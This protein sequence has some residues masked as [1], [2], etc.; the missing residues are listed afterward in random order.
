MLINHLVKLTGLFILIKTLQLVLVYITPRQFDL[1]SI[2]IKLISNKILDKIFNRFIHWDNVYF[3]KLFNIGPTFEHEWVFGPLWWRLINYAPIKNKFIFAIIIVQILNYLSMI[4][5]YELTFLKFKNYRKSLLTCIFF[6]YS[7]MGLFSII[8]YSENLSNFLI[9]FGLYLYNLNS[10]LSY[11]L[12][13]F[14][15]SLSIMT[16]S[17]TIIIG[18]LFFYDFIMG[19]SKKKKLFH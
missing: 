1:S 2:Q 6:I 13:S 17:N 15:F 3:N 19:N 7:P 12:S 14:I 8:P 10:N 9:I 18:F 11:L 5:I 4:I 16:R